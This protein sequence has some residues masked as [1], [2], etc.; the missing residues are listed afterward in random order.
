MEQKNGEKRRKS[1]PNF[2]KSNE[3]IAKEN[4]HLQSEP[5]VSTQSLKLEKSEG[6][7]IQPEPEKVMKTGDDENSGETISKPF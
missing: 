2:R 1:V 3:K 6:R 5:E 4:E 7:K